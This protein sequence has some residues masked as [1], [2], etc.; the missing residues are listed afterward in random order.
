MLKLSDSDE[1]S[2]SYDIAE[3]VWILDTKWTVGRT[4][5]KSICGQLFT[6]EQILHTL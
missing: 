3:V 5:C 4:L 2:S 6:C 1:L